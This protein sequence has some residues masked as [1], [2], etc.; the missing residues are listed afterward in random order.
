MQRWLDES[1]DFV[2]VVDGREFGGN[3]T[4]H[5]EVVAVDIG[6]KWHRL[7][8]FDEGVEDRLV[9]AVLAEHLLAEG[10]VL[11]HGD[12]LV[13]TAEERDLLWKV[14]FEREEKNAD[15]DGVVAAVD[16]VAQEEHVGLG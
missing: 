16:V 6:R 8:G 5:A 12:G 9:T 10:E 13:V 4:V 15:L 2:D 1:V 14:D 3:A 11:G 7:E